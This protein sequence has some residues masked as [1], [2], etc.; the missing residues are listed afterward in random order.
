MLGGYQKIIIINNTD[1]KHHPIILCKKQINNRSSAREQT[2]V[3]TNTYNKIQRQSLIVTIK[4]IMMFIK[5]N[6][7]LVRNVA[8][9]SVVKP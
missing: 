5:S 9:V 6:Y 2:T 4:D 3:N 1:V 8:E 7:K